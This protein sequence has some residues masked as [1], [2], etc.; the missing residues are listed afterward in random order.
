MN[1]YAYVSNNPVNRIDPSGNFDLSDTQGNSDWLN[2]NLN[3][4]S[5][6]LLGTGEYQG[7][8]SEYSQDTEQIQANSN[9]IDNAVDGTI[10]GGRQVVKSVADTG[11]AVSDTWHNIDDEHNAWLAENMYHMTPAETTTFVE[12]QGQQDTYKTDAAL[13]LFP[14]Y[15]VAKGTYQLSKGDY[16]DAGLSYAAVVPIGKVSGKFKYVPTESRD[17]VGTPFV[18][19]KPS[20]FSISRVKV[21]DYTKKLLTGEKVAPIEVARTPDGKLTIADGHH[22]FVASNRANVP[23]RM[24]VEYVSSLRSVFG[25]YEE[26]PDWSVVRYTQHLDWMDTSF[27]SK[28]S[29]VK[30]KKK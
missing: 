27:L 12:L 8:I 20:Q 7:A 26:L 6:G 21:D 18:D 17:I 28:T 4:W 23:I 3:Y 13:S 22:R 29:S 16:V 10:E 14:P 9:A 2:K 25:S 30:T 24:N 19:I 15:D 5:G 11:D 1:R